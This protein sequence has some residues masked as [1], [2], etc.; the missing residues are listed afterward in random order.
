MLFYK[1]MR[2]LLKF[3]HHRNFFQHSL[4][5]DIRWV[6]L[7]AKLQKKS[8]SEGERML[9]EHRLLEHPGWLVNLALV[10]W[11]QEHPQEAWDYL[12]QAIK[13][14]PSYPTPY[15]V[16]QFFSQDKKEQRQWQS[17]LAARLQLCQYNICLTQPN[18]FC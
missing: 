17:K 18:C 3:H 1:S 16:A 6:K 10:A 2:H 12:H 15:A 13:L 5:P 7:Q 4:V 8:F 11:N 9:K 14:S